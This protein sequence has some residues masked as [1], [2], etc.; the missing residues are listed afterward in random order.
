[1]RAAALERHLSARGLTL[2]HFPQSFEYVSLGGCA[3]TR[4]AGQASTGYGAIDKMVLGLRL[5]APAD[6]IELAAVPA[7]A[8]G[9]SLRQLLYAFLHRAG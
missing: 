8:A 2:G 4:S 1:M 3:A 9:P 6:D 5:A 7:S